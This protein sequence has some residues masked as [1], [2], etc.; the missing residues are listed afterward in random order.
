VVEPQYNRPLTQAKEFAMQIELIQELLE[1]LFDNEVYETE[2][3]TCLLSEEAGREIRERF[4][5][6]QLS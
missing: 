6:Q 4:V 3:V 5:Q 2:Q 1:T